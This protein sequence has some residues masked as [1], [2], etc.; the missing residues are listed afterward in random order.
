MTAVAQGGLAPLRREL[1]EGLVVIASRSEASPAVALS[2]SLESGSFHDPAEKPGVGHFLSRVIDRGT[3]NRSADD[4]ADLLD[5]AGVVLSASI[6]RHQLTLSC[7]CLADDFPDMLALVADIAR[8]PTLPDDE[9][10]TRRAEIVTGLV[11]DADNP[12]VVAGEGLFGLLYADG[13]PY[14]RRAKGTPA[15]V[16]RITRDDLAAF[17][18]A[19]IAAAPA[20]LVVVGNV[21]AEAAADRAAGVFAGWR[22]EHPVRRGRDEV[23][24]VPAAESRA[25]RRVAM[26]GK[27]QADVA[28]GFVTVRRDDPDYY[29][30]WLMNNVLG[31]YGL[32]GR[33]ADN[34]RERRGMAYYAFSIFDAGLGQGPIVIRAGVD[35]A[36]VER[37]IASID[38]EVA[39]MACD[40]VTEK[41]LVDS[42][43]YLTGSIPRM[44]ETNAGVAA[45]L[46][47]AEFFRLGLDHDRR[48]PAYIAAVTRDGVAAAARRFL[49]PERAAIVVAGPP[50]PTSP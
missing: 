5:T 43:Q 19:R 41:E 31:Q 26:P 9:V 18:A 39:R 14:G 37:V 15:S 10:E 30:V 20:T 11:Q 34:I 16:Q 13:H 35:P 28:Y 38:E 47:A 49:S 1:D 50:G 4:I 3:T 48:L 24:P 22:S 44:L 7:T 45:F 40:G 6:T 27:V 42:K 23:P 17:H 12:A 29:D 32:G 21:D 36:N 8:H 2:L 46:Q 25:E 33:L